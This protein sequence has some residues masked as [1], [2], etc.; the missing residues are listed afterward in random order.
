MSSR[1]NSNRN[2][3]FLCPDSLIPSCTLKLSQK[4][5]EAPTV[6]QGQSNTKNP[7]FF[8]EKHWHRFKGHWDQPDSVG[9]RPPRCEAA[10]P[11]LLCKRSLL[12]ASPGLRACERLA[13]W[14]E[15]MPH[16]EY[17][18]VQHEPFK[19]RLQHLQFRGSENWDSL[20]SA[21]T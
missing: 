20:D 6:V 17:Q 7:K 1:S 10:S 11:G 15:A 19:T 12:R 3:P 9:T 18:D 2:R 13:L 14:R 4:H 5:P 16:G 8:R 21:D